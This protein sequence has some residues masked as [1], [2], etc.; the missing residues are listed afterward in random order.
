[1]TRAGFI[2]ATVGSAVGLGNVWR[3][4][5]IAVRSGGGAFLLLYL[6]VVLVVGIPLMMSELALGRR[7]RRGVVGAFR[8]IRPGSGW[9]AVGV[10][11]SLAVFMI[12]SYY[13]VI[14]GWTLTYTLLSASGSTSGLGS[15]G[16][17]ELFAHLTQDVLLPIYGQ[18][19]LLLIAVTI[20]FSGVTA[21][22]ERWGRILTPG[23]VLLL[24]LLLGRVSLL[25]GG[26][27]GM[28]WF[29]RPDFSRISLGV[30]LEVVG[31]VFFSFSLGMGAVLT[32]GSYLGRSDDI[33]L[34]SLIISLADV[35]IA[36][37]AGAVVTAAL[38]AFGIE[39]E[40]GFGLLFIAL[41][42]VFN[43][44]PAAALWSTAFFMALAFAALTSL[45]SFLEVLCALLIEETGWPRSRAA[46]IV[47]TLC[48]IAGI[49]SALSQSLLKA[50]RIAGWDVMG[51][52]DTISSNIMLPLS[53]L[54]TTLFVA[55]VW[56]ARAAGDEIALGSEASR[57]VPLWRFIIRYA[58]PV[59][60]T[61]ILIV[62]LV[63]SV[64]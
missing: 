37:L 25:D 38:F 40:A 12:A 53:G 45:I 9:W 4:P 17:T 22:I 41:P 63:S 51:L 14:A 15:A 8:Q 55:W 46:V 52:V 56:G 26:P 54:L 43:T 2:L 7:S 19:A 20:V 3:F 57:V 23:I 30:A 36:V 34:N 29:L 50:V 18:G 6:A 39:P 27:T 42:A 10:I 33:P 1:A 48:F 35:G 11:A 44:L 31:Q 62:G 60:L 49:P 32:Y 59:V 58:A 21:G 61:Y 24:L 64:G 5:A 28:A 47:G 13:S 16:L